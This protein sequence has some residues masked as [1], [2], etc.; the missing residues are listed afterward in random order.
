MARV[1][2][3]RHFVAAYI[4]GTENPGAHGVA[5]ACGR[6]LFGDLRQR[7]TEN[8]GSTTCLVCRSIIE[9]NQLRQRLAELNYL[10]RGLR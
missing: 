4:G 9:R 3:T 1:F 5:T 10:S 7:T 8:L 2:K 6:F